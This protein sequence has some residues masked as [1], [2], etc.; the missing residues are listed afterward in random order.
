MIALGC[1]IR[2][3]TAHFEHVAGQC[4]SG[5]QQ[6][7]L[8]TGVPV[9]FGVLTTEDL[10]QALSRSEGAGGHNVGEEGAL[11]AVAMARLLG[12]IRERG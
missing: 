10:D 3:D 2:G 12:R 8:E 5:L 11:G 4:A 6:A 1:V 9:L 7:S